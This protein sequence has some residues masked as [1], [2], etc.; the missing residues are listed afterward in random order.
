MCDCP[1]A[2]VDRLCQVLGE[3]DTHRIV[4][5]L[6]MTIGQRTARALL[7]ETAFTYKLM[8]TR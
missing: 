5:K 7:S 1:Q 8:R 6:V 3:F 4:Y 2:E